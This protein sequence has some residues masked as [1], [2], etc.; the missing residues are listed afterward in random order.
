MKLAYRE[1]DKGYPATGPSFLE[2]IIINWREAE[3]KNGGEKEIKWMK[4]KGKE[5]RAI[6]QRDLPSFLPW[7][8]YYK[9]NEREREKQEEKQGKWMKLKGKEWKA[10]LQQDLPSFFEM[11][12]IYSKARER[13]K[14]KE[15]ERNEWYCNGNGEGLSCNV[16]FFSSSLK[17]LLDAEEGGRRKEKKKKKG[18]SE[19]F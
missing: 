8:A 4:F 6:L 15:N 16:T 14:C 11:L 18:K 5:R 7:N 12:I 10:I 3:R 19:F 1:R 9:F 17:C 2:V 13:K